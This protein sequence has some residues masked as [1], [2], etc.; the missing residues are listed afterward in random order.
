MT[1]LEDRVARLAREVDEVRRLASGA[2]TLKALRETQLEQGEEMR[3]G[4]AE[5]RAEFRDVR[6]EIAGVRTEMQEGFAAINA[7]MSQM[8]AL[9]NKAIGRD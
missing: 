3:R 7:N 2:H 8:T 9:L 5:V 1:K 6:A 4:F